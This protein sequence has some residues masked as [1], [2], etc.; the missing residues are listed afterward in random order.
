L[1]TNPPTL[2]GDAILTLIGPDG[3]DSSVHTTIPAGSPVM[4]DLTTLPGAHAMRL[5][6]TA[7]DGRFPVQEER[8]TDIVVRITLDG[9]ATTVSGI[10]PMPEMVPP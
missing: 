9:C 5:N 2:E 10:R 8:V 6:G 3:I 7:C 4:V 1:V